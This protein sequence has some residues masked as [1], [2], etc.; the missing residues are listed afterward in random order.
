LEKVD[1]VLE[2]Y[3]VEYPQV[4]PVSGVAYLPL[5][6]FAACA[7][8]GIQENPG[9]SGCTPY[10]PT[11]TF[12]A[13]INQQNIT[14]VPYVCTDFLQTG[15]PTAPTTTSAGAPQTTTIGASTSPATAPKATTGAATN[16]TSSATA[17]AT[18]SSTTQ[19]SAG[20]HN[21]SS[22]KNSMRQF[23]I[24][25]SILSFLRYRWVVG[26]LDSFDTCLI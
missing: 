11:Y 19:K 13:S 12:Q 21:Q 15:S 24:D 22:R 17:A 16:M 14:D 26:D 2:A 20:S 1:I 7:T 9:Q 23:L 5:T 6:Q 4:A 10:S 8:V 18:S 3:A 25:R